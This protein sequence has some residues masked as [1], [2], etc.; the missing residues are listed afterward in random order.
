MG[1]RQYHL[2][3]GN[4]PRTFFTRNQLNDPNSKYAALARDGVS[5][6]VCHQMIDQN[7]DD[8]S[9]YTGKFLLGP[10]GQVFGP[11]PSG[12]SLEKV[13][14]DDKLGGNP[15]GIWISGRG[16]KTVRLLP[17]DRAPRL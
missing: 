8:P 15:T 2:D 12:N 5:C 11:Y 10:P 17:H 14:A 9:T 7:L 6:M 16:V 1:Q 13:G 3:K 4:G